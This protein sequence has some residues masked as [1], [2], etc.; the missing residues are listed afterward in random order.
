MHLLTLGQ[1]AGEIEKFQ[2]LPPERE[3]LVVPQKVPWC[4]PPNQ[5]ITS[6][7]EVLIENEKNRQHL[8][9]SNALNG[10]HEIFAISDTSRDSVRDS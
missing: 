7:V 8:S 5:T 10:N 2:H 6:G 9:D 3:I 4:K 1:L